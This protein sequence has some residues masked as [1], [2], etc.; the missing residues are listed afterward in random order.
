MTLAQQQPDL[1]L[2]MER[3]LRERRIAGTEDH[4]LAEVS[5]Q[6]LLQ[7]LLDVD[8]R[9]HAE[10]LFLESCCRPIDRPLELNISENAS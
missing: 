6:L 10:A 5:I 3:S 4:I 8:R 7:G 9:E 1:Q 2:G